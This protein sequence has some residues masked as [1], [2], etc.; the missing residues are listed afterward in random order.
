MILSNEIQQYCKSNGLRCTNKRLM[1]ADFL[2]K[3]KGRAEAETLYMMFRK[4]S[5]R[6]SQATIY[7]MLDWMVKQGFVEHVPGNNRRNMYC[8]R[9]LD[10]VAK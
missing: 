1:L 4:N 6:I 7:Q 2:Q 5:V 9:S 8:V 3:E 10:L